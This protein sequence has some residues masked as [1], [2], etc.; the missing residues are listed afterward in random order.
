MNETAINPE[1]DY[2]NPDYRNQL[3]FELLKARI[4]G[5][6]QYSTGHKDRYR[7]EIRECFEAANEFI[8]QSKVYK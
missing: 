1:S 5:G 4:I 2:V 6:D 8:R 3:A 7:T